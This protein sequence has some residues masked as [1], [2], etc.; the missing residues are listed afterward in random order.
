MIEPIQVSE[1]CQYTKKEQTELI[2]D[3]FSKISQ[4]YDAL[5]TCDLSV[6][7]FTMDSIPHISQLKVRKTLKHIKTKPSFIPGDILSIVLKN[8]ANQIA[9]PLTNIINSCI[10]EGQ[11]PDIWKEEAV[12]HI[13]KVH[14][15]IEI[16][17]L[18]NISGLK[19]KQSNGENFC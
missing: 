19:F 10:T 5:R 11:W 12:T 17:D 8:L 13:P 1:I 6:L 18:R 15:P 3:Q 7:D 4:E 16:D 9:I 14:P 2:A